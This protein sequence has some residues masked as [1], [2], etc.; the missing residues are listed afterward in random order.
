MLKPW[1][2][3][4]SQIIRCLIKPLKKQNSTQTFFQEGTPWVTEILNNCLDGTLLCTKTFGVIVFLDSK[5]NQLKVD[6]TELKTT[7]FQLKS[8]LINRFL[9][10]LNGKSIERRFT[11]IESKLSSIEI[12]SY[13]YRFLWRL[14]RISIESRFKWIES[15][16]FSTE[17]LSYQ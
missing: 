10:G 7:W 17:I 16:L 5:E 1:K 13:Q 2:C 4:V 14:K 3:K 9:W 12:L 11:W 15:K 6:S 8:F